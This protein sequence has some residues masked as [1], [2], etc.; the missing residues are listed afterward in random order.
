[1]TLSLLIVAWD[2]TA[3]SVV[4][5]SYNPAIGSMAQCAK[6][7]AGRCTEDLG[8]VATIKFDAAHI[9]ACGSMRKGFELATFNRIW[10]RRILAPPPSQTAHSLSPRRRSG[11]RVRER[12]SQSAS[13]A[14]KRTPLPNPLPAR[15]SRGE[16]AMQRPRWWEWPDAPLSRW[17][18]S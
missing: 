18:T 9:V 11:E 5:A 14:Q 12:G 8:V 1:M 16:G 6:P 4:A 15:A 13:R 2:P 7:V 10:L 17:T 3:R